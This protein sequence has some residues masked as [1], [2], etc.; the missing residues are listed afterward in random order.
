MYWTGWIR[1]CVHSPAR[2]ESL[3]SDLRGNTGGGIGG[4]RLVS[5][6]TPGKLDVG[7]SLTR[8][9]KEKGHAREE[10]T[11]LVEYHRGNRG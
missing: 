9:R 5:Y 3:I 7:Y 1:Q 8:N 4:L 2:I 6:L 11:R 10:L